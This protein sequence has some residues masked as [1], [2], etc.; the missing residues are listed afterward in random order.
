MV[1]AS[2]NR[3]IF[4]SGVFNFGIPH[5]A[6]TTIVAPDFGMA[7]GEEQDSNDTSVKW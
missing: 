1:P 7:S 3:D 5:R 6:S 4:A 2:D